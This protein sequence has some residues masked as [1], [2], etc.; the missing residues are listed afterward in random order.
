[1]VFKIFQKLF[2]TLYN[3][4][5]FSYFFDYGNLLILK[6]LTETLIRVQL[7]VIGRCSLFQAGYYKDFQN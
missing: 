6:M 5:L 7:S 2:T 4:K 3:Y 1:M